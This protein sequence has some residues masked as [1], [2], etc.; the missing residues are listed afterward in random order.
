VYAVALLRGRND[1]YHR[2]GFAIPFV[3][4]A[5]VTP[6]Q[7]VVGDWAARF[8]SA[9]Q[10]TKLAAMEGVFRTGSHVP[11]TIGGVAGGSGNGKGLQYGLEIPSGLS[12]LVGFHPGTVVQGLNK[13]PRDQWPA[14]T[15]V[16]LSF[17]VMVA[18]GFFLLA[19]GACLLFAWWR[20][21]RTGRDLLAM[22]GS[23]LFLRLAVVTGPAAVVALE[24]G[25]T[26]T[27]LGRQPW[28]VW[29]VMRVRDAVNPAPG[30]MAGL[31][32]VLAVYA[33]MTT[34]TV[35][36]LRRL[37]R[38]RPVPIAPQEGDVQDYPVV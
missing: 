17:D 4:G 21:R 10:P 7:I 26:V 14:V 29:G 33:A 13:V 38:D 15:G 6:F 11:L 1:A 34:A 28:I 27:E 25:W 18:V 32:M 23:R 36:V 19:M 22:R 24:C 30:L 20:K 3:L 2:V 37:A 5:V 16:H 35:Y 31:W 9:Y 12:L 8:L